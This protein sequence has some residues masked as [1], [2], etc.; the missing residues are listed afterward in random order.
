MKE[1]LEIAVNSVAGCQLQYDSFYLHSEDAKRWCNSMFS[2]NIR[3]LNTAQGNRSAIC[4]DRGRLQGLIDVYYLGD[5]R[6]LCILDGIDKE[7]FQQRFSMYMILDDIEHQPLQEE[8]IHIC[9]PESTAL[10]KKQGYVIPDPNQQYSQHSTVQLMRKNRFGVDGF[11]LISDNIPALIQELSLA[12][13]QKIPSAAMDAL[14]IT[15]GLAKWPDDGTEKTMIHELALNEE[16]CA[17][18]KG[19]YI[20][21]EIINRIDVKGILNKRIHK[22]LI[23]GEVNLGDSL[24][25]NEQAVG[26]VTSLTTIDDQQ[27]GLSVLKKSAWINGAILNISSGGTATVVSQ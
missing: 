7:W 17:F 12:G 24:Q 21:Q 11:D 20:G 27:V 19:C 6:F 1:W 13:M 15:N 5:D 3:K 18:D 10:L 14:R 23:S 25:L 2:N 16:C 22:I 9:G 8:L 26:K 4:D